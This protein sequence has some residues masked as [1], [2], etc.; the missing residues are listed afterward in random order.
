MAR[1][2]ITGNLTKDVEL[3][4]TNSGMTVANFSIAESYKPSRDKDE[5]T[6]FWNVTVWN[7]L[8]ENFAESCKKG[9]RVVVEG[10]LVQRTWKSDDDVQHSRVEIVADSAGPDLRF[11]TTTY[12]KSAP[13]AAAGG[14]SADEELF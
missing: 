6:Y 2:S 5:E 14:S 1:V 3:K 4:F 13:K 8:A 10:R 7:Q 11:G 12:T 9:Q